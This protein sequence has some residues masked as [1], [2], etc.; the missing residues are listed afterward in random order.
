MEMEQKC[1]V[2]FLVEHLQRRNNRK[3]YEAKME[4]TAN[5]IKALD[6]CLVFVVSLCAIDVY[7]PINVWTNLAISIGLG[8]LFAYLLEARNELISKIT[9]VVSTAFWAVVIALLVTY[10][11]IGKKGI[12]TSVAFIAICI[13]CSAIVWSIHGRAFLGTGIVRKVSRGE[14]D[15]DTVVLE[16]L[17]LSATEQYE[18]NQKLIA[19]HNI[20]GSEKYIERYNQAK[21]KKEEFQEQIKT[22]RKLRK[23][24]PQQHQIYQ[25][26][27]RKFESVQALGQGVYDQI[28][29]MIQNAEEQK[30]TEDNSKSAE[31]KEKNISFFN[32]CQDFEAVKKRYYALCKVYHPDNEVGDEEAFRKMEEEYQ[33][34]K[35]QYASA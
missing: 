10:Y 34:L 29:E 9:C 12:W 17:F 35:K 25:D 1:I 15:E 30:R 21:I 32:G 2:N 24:R 20:A 18:K 22:N 11:A 8:S 7:T 31:P 26:L 13:V 27:I 6:G 28:I 5:I 33:R 4:K 23:N 3:G 16:A 19:K 14:I